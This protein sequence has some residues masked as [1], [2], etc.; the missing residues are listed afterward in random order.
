DGGDAGDEY[1]Y[2][3]PERDLVV[4]SPVDVTTTL[5]AA[6]PLEARVRVSTRLKIPSG[7]ATGRRSRGRRRVWMPVTTEYILRAGEPFLRADITVINP[8]EDHRLRAHVPLPFR[9]D[10]SHADQAFW[11]QERGL[12]AEGAGHEHPLPT[13]PAKRFV[14]ASDGT[15]GMAVLLAGTPEFE[16][17]D[18]ADIA[19]TL[20]R[21][22]GWLSRQ[23]LRYRSGPAGPAFEAPGAQCEGEYGFS[24]A[25]YPHT[26]DWVSG[27]VAAA[28]EQFSLPL[29]AIGVRAHAGRLPLAGEALHIEPSAVRLSALERRDGAVDLRVY[30]AAADPVEAV[31][32][33]GAPLE[34]ER[35]GIVDL[36]GNPVGDVSL[37]GDTISLPMRGGQI[38]T[39]RLS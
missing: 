10:R 30:N 28:A 38:V 15:I 7:L 35:A 26:G 5:V 39:I 9:T 17:V 13:F 23:D 12:V 27:G 31:I 36:V 21:C 33:I 4:S 8:A 11:V 25:L 34:A 2:S 19:V 1:T 29:R 14:D 22:V 20:L 18:G 3:P 6:G 37:K 32:K 24:F 16:L